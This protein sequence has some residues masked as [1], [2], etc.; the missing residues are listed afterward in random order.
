VFFSLSDYLTLNTNFAMA[1]RHYDYELNP[2]TFQFERKKV[3][4]DLFPSLN[5]LRSPFWE[6]YFDMEYYFPEELAS[7][8][9]IGFD[10]RVEIKNEQ[11]D[12]FNPI[13]PTR[14]TTLPFEIQKVWSEN[15]ITK[16]ISESQ[17]VFEY[18][19][20]ERFFNQFFNV[21]FTFFSKYSA[22]FRYELTTNKFETGGRKNWFVFEGGVRFESNHTF[23]LSYGRERGG[24][25]C[26]NGIC[27][28][29]LPF[30]GLRITLNTNI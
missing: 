28:Q 10:R 15:L 17:W 29:V 1:S 25:V 16:F 30:D 24:T 26:S 20:T 27:R 9:R 13:Q 19:Q 2:S 18:P 14:I 21:S 22:G 11:M 7:Y 12:F 5:K 6:I 3:G 8:L 4:S 23:I